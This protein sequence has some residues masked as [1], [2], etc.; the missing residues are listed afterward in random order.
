MFASDLTIYNKMLI[1]DTFIGSIL[2]QI[3]IVGLFFWTSFF[4]RYF[5]DLGR[6][7][8]MPG[9]IIIISQLIISVLSEN[10]L[11]LTSFFIP[12]LL[13]VLANKYELHENSNNRN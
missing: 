12:G 1:S 5:I 9:S 11:N 6:R 2:G 13:A 3:G 10:T 7:I 8:I 4:S